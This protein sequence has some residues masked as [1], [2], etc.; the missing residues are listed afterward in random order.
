MF[1]NALYTNTLGR[2]FIGKDL[3]LGLTLKDQQDFHEFRLLHF[4]PMLS[5]Y[6]HQSID[7]Q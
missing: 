3:P 5:L 1:M 4:S 6:R 7:L 2:A